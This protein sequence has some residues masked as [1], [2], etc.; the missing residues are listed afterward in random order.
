M[1]AIIIIDVIHHL[2]EVIDMSVDQSRGMEMLHALETELASKPPGHRFTA[3]EL[4]MV[5][6]LHTRGYT[7]T[8]DLARVAQITEDTY[9]L[10]IGA[11]L[12]G[13]ARYLA[14]TYGCCVEGVDSEP[15]LVEAAKYLSTRWAGPGDRVTFTVDDACS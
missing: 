6:H 9:V 14:E 1:T 5:D 13:P 2:I 3:P 8:V 11:G 7:A 4:A 15:G 12:G 10:D